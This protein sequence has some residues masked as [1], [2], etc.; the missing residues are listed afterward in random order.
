MRAL[1]HRTELY[2]IVSL[3]FAIGAIISESFWNSLV[4]WYSS[5][6]QLVR[7]PYPHYC[8]FSCFGH[9]PG[10]DD[11]EHHFYVRYIKRLFV[12]VGY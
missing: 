7:S 11:L 6:L 8:L 4:V 1:L 10:L 5:S 3:A 9:I 12:L 2:E